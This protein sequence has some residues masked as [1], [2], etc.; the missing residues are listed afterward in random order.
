[1]FSHLQ[2]CTVGSYSEYNVSMDGDGVLGAKIGAKTAREA[3]KLYGLIL[4]HCGK[5]RALG[6]RPC[7]VQVE[8]V[9]NSSSRQSFRTWFAGDKIYV[10]CFIPGR[11]V[12]KIWLMEGIHQSAQ[13]W[14]IYFLNGLSFFAYHALFSG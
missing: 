11:R 12:N 2:L 6:D 5:L 1:M 4:H 10:E 7:V 14:S 3:A 13:P 9:G 8:E